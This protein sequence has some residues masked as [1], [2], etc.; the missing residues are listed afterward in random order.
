[1]AHFKDRKMESRIISFDVA[2]AAASDDDDDD[3]E[4]KGKK[5]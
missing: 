5:L 2:A 3:V 1:M 4:R